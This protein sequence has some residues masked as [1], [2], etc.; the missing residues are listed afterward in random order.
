[1]NKSKDVIGQLEAKTKELESQ[2]AS[3]P[4]MLASM[5]HKTDQEIQN[6]KAETEAAHSKNVSIR[7]QT[8]DVCRKNMSCA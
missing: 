1:M 8:E 3:V 5:R 4:G 2:S 7:C 6:Y